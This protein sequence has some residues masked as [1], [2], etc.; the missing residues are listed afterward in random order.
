MSGEADG[1]IVVDVG[2]TEMPLLIRE[3]PLPEAV[4]VEDGILPP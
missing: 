2:V 4:D 1:S 3:R